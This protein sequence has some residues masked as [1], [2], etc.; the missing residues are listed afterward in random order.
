MNMYPIHCMHLDTC[1]KLALHKSFIYLLTNLLIC[2][3]CVRRCRLGHVHHIA[4]H[5]YLL[6]YDH[7]LVFLLYVCLLRQRCALE[8]LQ[9]PLELTRQAM[10]DIHSLGYRRKRGD[11]PQP[12]R[13]G[14]PPKPCSIFER[15]RSASVPPDNRNIITTRLAD[16]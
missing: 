9:P 16:L 8:R 5:W 6:Q 2:R 4:L 7:R 13:Q 1:Q 12:L 11:C 3:N 15:F 10:A 14:R